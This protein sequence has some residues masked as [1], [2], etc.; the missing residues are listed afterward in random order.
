MTPKYTPARL[1][2]DACVV[3]GR[4]AASA[5]QER[6]DALALRACALSIGAHQARDRVLYPVEVT[7]GATDLDG[8][9]DR[10]G[11]LDMLTRWS[12][13]DRTAAEAAALWLA[14]RRA[15]ANVAAVDAP[16]LAR[17]AAGW[18]VPEEVARTAVV[19]AA[20]G[21]LMARRLPG[22]DI[23]DPLR[24]ARQAYRR[25]DVPV[26][27]L[28]ALWALAD[29]MEVARATREFGDLDAEAQAIGRA[30]VADTGPVVTVRVPYEH[31]GLGG[32]PRH[33]YHL[34]QVWPDCATGDADARYRAS[35]PDAVD[36]RVMVQAAIGRGLARI[37]AAPT[38]V[39]S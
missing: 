11:R 2:L 10:V 24:V 35:D 6:G 19:W 39:P 13:D 1:V 30:H 28:D 36:I 27:A 7:M 34:G 20:G 17:L 23:G 38:G 37:A 4:L 9:M 31:G 22:V 15:I 32:G 12:W 25:H 14:D 29:R 21:A 16:V 18:S 3:N 26:A 33:R 8:L 5:W